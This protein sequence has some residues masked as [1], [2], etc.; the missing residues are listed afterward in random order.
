MVG[1]EGNPILKNYAIYIN[2]LGDFVG[3]N[4]GTDWTF[5]CTR[6]KLLSVRVEQLT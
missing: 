3:T 6:C 4:V 2:K 1:P 5:F